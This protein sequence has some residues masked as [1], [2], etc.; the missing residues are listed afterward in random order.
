MNLGASRQRPH[1]IGLPLTSA[2]GS[3]HATGATDADSA[4]RPY[5]NC[6]EQ[7]PIGARFSAP[8]PPYSNHSDTL[9]KAEVVLS[10]MAGIFAANAGAGLQPWSIG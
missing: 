1:T 8:Q 2:A 4:V 9:L 3:A 10:R 5:P 7:A 6:L